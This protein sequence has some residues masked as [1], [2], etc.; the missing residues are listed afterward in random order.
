MVMCVTR[1]RSPGRGHDRLVVGDD[2]RDGYLLDNR[3]ALAG[4]RLAAL[5]EVFDPWTYRHMEGLGVGAGWRCWEVGAG[6]PSVPA[7]LVGRTRPGGHV[8]ATDIDLTWLSPTDPPGGA[9][10]EVRQHDVGM[11][12]LPGNDFDLVH[13]RLVLV[14]VVQR[15]A[16]LRAMVAA[17]RTGGWL[18]LEE[19]D[20]MLQPLACPD[21]SGPGQQLANVLRRGF[22][23]LMAERGVDLAFG[24]TLPRLMREAGLVEVQAE[25]FFPVTSP[26]GAR[27]E[28]ATVRQVRHRLVAGGLASEA[29]IDRHLRN[30]AAG[31]LDIATAPL[32]TAWGRRPVRQPSGNDASRTWADRPGTA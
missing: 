4:G 14:H 22:R 11:D 12:P 6:A 13:A 15:D 3:Q 5:A 10:F 9:T 32:V 28:E 24:R 7:W 17:L 31:M 2:A 27:L 1:T 16:V 20:P 29:D 19:A 21:E 25:A 8:L 26:A 18:M 23:T 30:L